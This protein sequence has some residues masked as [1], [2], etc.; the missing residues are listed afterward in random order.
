MDISKMNSKPIVLLD[1]DNTLTNSNADLN[2][3]LLKVLE[4]YGLKR[5]ILFTS[6]DLQYGLVGRIKSYATRYDIIRRLQRYGFQIDATIISCSPYKEDIL[7][8]YYHS[9]IYPLE[10]A[11]IDCFLNHEGSITLPQILKVAE[12]PEQ[13]AA[14]ELKLIQKSISQPLHGIVPWQENNYKNGKLSLLTHIIHH[15]TKIKQTTQQLYSFIVFDD[16]PEVVNVVTRAASEK[17]YG[18]KVQLAVIPVNF[19]L[20]KQ[21]TSDYYEQKLQE[22]YQA[23]KLKLPLTSSSA[24][25][26]KLSQQHWLFIDELNT[27]HEAIANNGLSWLQAYDRIYFFGFNANKLK[28]Q[29]IQQ[30]P[31]LAERLHAKEA[32]EPKHALASLDY[33]SQLASQSLKFSVQWHYTQLGVPKNKATNEAWMKDVK[34][35]P[36]LAAT[37]KGYQCLTDLKITLNKAQQDLVSNKNFFQ[38]LNKA[39]SS[40]FQQQLF[41]CQK[42]IKAPQQLLEKLIL[43]RELSRSSKKMLKILESIFNAYE[44]P[45]NKTINANSWLHLLLSQHRP[46]IEK[47]QFIKVNQKVAKKFITQSKNEHNLMKEWFAISTATVTD[48]DA[49]QIRYEGPSP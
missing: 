20:V 22:A 27:A 3:S 46:A 16:K 25:P 18:N 17:L 11:G 39:F 48:F 2:I 23:L 35:D 34:S 31:I 12:Q 19:S 8:D 36:L 49:N 38:R 24:L 47:E 33:W 15:T 9:V 41:I 4:K 7:G 43:I 21:D 10:K 42:L 1:V 30:Q 29:V 45:L 40:D 37:I 6:Y 28:E 13:L 26:E 44:I 5:V 14:D 32:L